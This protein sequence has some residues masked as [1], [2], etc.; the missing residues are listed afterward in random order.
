M[1]VLVFIL[2]VIILVITLINFF[3]IEKILDNTFDLGHDLAL[4]KR[5]SVKRGKK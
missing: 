3:E 5:K 1:I 2:F 4:L